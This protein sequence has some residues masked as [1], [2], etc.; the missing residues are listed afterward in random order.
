MRF[1]LEENSPR[2]DEPNAGHLRSPQLVDG[3]R[4]IA[5]PVHSCPL[6]I[7]WNRAV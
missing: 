7:D 5:L 1:M 2:C 3:G 6:V 4:D